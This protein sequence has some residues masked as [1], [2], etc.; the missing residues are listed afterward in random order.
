MCVY[1]YGSMWIFS[2][3]VLLQAKVERGKGTQFNAANNNLH[4]G[5]YYDYVYHFSN[6]CHFYL[7]LSLP[8]SVYLFL[9]VFVCLCGLSDIACIWVPGC[10]INVIDNVS[11]RE[12]DEMCRCWSRDKEAWN[13]TRCI[14]K[15]D[16]YPSGTCKYKILLCMRSD[17]DPQA[18]VLHVKC[19]YHM[20]FTLVRSTFS[21]QAEPVNFCLT[22]VLKMCP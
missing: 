14:S 22:A 20:V 5:M 17:L 9:C 6:C 13:S 18:E 8:V 4:I 2:L 19:I 7:F 3:T 11:S 10:S 1:T 15:K 21:S 12:P 16:I